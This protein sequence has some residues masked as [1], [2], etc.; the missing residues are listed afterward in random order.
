ME[1]EDVGLLKFD[2]L[3][4][5]TLSIIGSALKKIKASKG[6]DIDL[7][8]LNLDDEKTFELIRNCETV[9]LFQIEGEGMKRSIRTIHPDTVEDLCYLVAAYRPGPMELIPEYAAVKNGKKKAEYLLPELEPILSPTNGVISYQEQVIRIAVDIAGYSLG[10]ADAF[11][12]AMGKKLI[13][14]MEKEKAP[15]MEG[16]LKK[17]FDKRKIEELWA[18]LFK[19]ANYGFNKAHSA[20]YAVVAYW[21]AY[22]KAHYPLEYMAALLEGDLE[23]FDRVVLDLEECERLGFNVLPPAINNSGYFFRAEGDNSIRFGLGAIKN[24]GG[25]IIKEILLERDSNGKFASLD[26]FISRTLNKGVQPRVVEYLIKSGA[27]DEFG[28]RQAQ[29]QVMEGLFDLHKKQNE[30]KS[31]GQIDLFG[32]SG[33]PKGKGTSLV[34]EDVITPSSKLLEWEKELLGIYFSSHPLDSLQTFFEEKDVTAIRDIKEKRNREIVVLGVL[35]S[36]VKRITTKKGERM[37][38]LTVEDKSGSTDVIVFPR[39]YEEMKD[40]FE[41]NKPVLIAGRTNF[42]DGQTSIVFEKAKY[43]DEEKF[44]DEFSGV[45]FKIGKNHKPE[46]ISELRSFIRKTPGN[47][48]VKI[49]MHTEE[50]LKSVVLNYKIALNTEAKNLMRKFS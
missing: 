11:R 14:V 28:D 20:M 16:A 39:S 37:A 48:P 47:T 21:T 30:I 29:L 18:L 13:D 19:F 6:V 4:Q 45:V 1:L 35:I 46:E 22:L 36:N 9:G 38:F 25:D 42:R 23:R 49:L 32:A 50:G 2:F 3:G 12:K 43:I 31:L 26:D 27:M 17:G 5:R 24:V 41:A 33:E 44:A 34:P 15:F 7:I 8:K 10:Q 40:S